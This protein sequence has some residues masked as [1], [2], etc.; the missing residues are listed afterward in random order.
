[1]KLAA[2][3]CREDEIRFFEVYADQYGIE[4]VTTSK[5]PAPETV[6]IAKGCQ[7]VSVITTPITAEILEKFHEYG[8]K[9]VSTRTVGYEHVDCKRAA[10]LGITVSNVSYTPNTVAEYAVMC[11][12]M[13]LRKMKTIMNRY[14][15]QDY[16]LKDVRGRE[17]R[18][19]TVGVIGTGRIGETVIRNLSGF[20]CRMLAYDLFQKDSVIKYAAYASLEQ[21]WQ[22]CDVI[23]LHAPATDESY[24]MINEESIG[25]MKDG[26]VIVNTARG[27]LIDT[28]ALINGLTAGKIGAAALDVIEN[29]GKI[30]YKDFKYQIVKHPQLILLNSMPNVLMTPHTAFF[31]DEAVGDMVEF[32]IKSCIQTVSGEENP[33]KV[34]E[35]EYQ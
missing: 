11:M 12:L 4:L 1:M 2:F 28:D 5:T 29:E 14:I 19:L 32:S 22:E 26:V 8:V 13:A 23:T 21:I 20:G 35:P 17:I 6:D 7:A 27:S 25:K 16:G 9:V 33:W 15:G 18:N 30:Y 3:N 24:H 10:E 31:T 34:N